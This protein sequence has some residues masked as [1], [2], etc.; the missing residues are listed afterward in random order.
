MKCLIIQ[1]IIPDVEVRSAYLD[2]A[3]QTTYRGYQ[4]H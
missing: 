3:Y 1:K 2:I 4:T